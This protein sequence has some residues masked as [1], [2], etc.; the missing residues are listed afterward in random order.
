[1]VQGRRTVIHGMSSPATAFTLLALFYIAFQFL[2]R[3]TPLGMFGD[4][5]LYSSISRNL[6]EGTGTWWAPFFSSGYWL[7]E[8]AP[9]A[10]WENPPLM[11]WMQSAFFWL[12]GDHW[13]VEKLY[14][15]LLLLVNCILIAR[16]WSI[17][18][19]RSTIHATALQWMPVWFFYLIPIVVWGS[20][21]N[22]IDS[23]LLMFC[24]LANGC[25]LQAMHVKR[26]TTL[27]FAAA[28]IF[29]LLGILTKGPVALYPVCIPALYHL[30]MDRQHWMK[31]IIQSAVIGLAVAGL[32]TMLLL[33][34]EPARYFF[35]QYWEQRL[36]VAIEGGRIDG[37]RTGWGRLYIFWLLLRENAMILPVSMLLLFI[38]WRKRL[39][40]KVYAYERRVTL[41]YFLLALCATVPVMASTR[42]AGMYLI[43]GL[44][45]FAMAAGY[46]HAPLFIKW[47]S[48]ITPKTN[49]IISILA[50]VGIGC[51][52]VHA[53]M[54]GGR[55]GRERALLHDLPH[56]QKIIPAG[57]RVAVCDDVMSNFVYHV[58]LQRF[59]KIELTRDPDQANFHIGKG[60]CTAEEIS[61][62]LDA[63]FLEVYA[64]EDVVLSRRYRSPI[65]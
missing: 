61:A 7:K 39:L 56:L 6:A 34:H 40:L 44:A 55:P 58:Y 11:F 38:A 46:L 33:V 65:K 62:L 29:I 27:L 64:G 57:A 16:V 50:A 10:Y 47:F 41:F 22:L 1:M 52:I 20:P 25:L 43:P 2:P 4:G 45:L 3:L 28:T 59:H 8:V 36:S 53:V 31:G 21:H 19:N 37:L 9:A 35:T 15:F 51:V 42:Q 54:I 23:Q 13:W 14:T 12:F 48:T 18:W 63:G 49:R 32:F 17:L 26:N 30:V 60:K 5:L 24:L